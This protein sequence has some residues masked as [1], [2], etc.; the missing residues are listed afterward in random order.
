MGDNLSRATVQAF[1]EALG[2]RD[3]VRLS[4]HL[5]DD[6]EWHM[7]GPVHLLV[8]CGYRRGKAA[9]ADCIGRLL[10]SMFAVRRYEPE[11]IIIDGDTAA[12]LINVTAVQKTTGRTLTYQ[13]AMFAVFQDGKVKSLKSVADTFDMAEQVVGHRIDAYCTP[14]VPIGDVIAL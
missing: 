6:V 10:P 1:C 4:Q 2:S 7:V 11:E 5:T 3:P 14:E 8:Y 12:I 13:T 9:V